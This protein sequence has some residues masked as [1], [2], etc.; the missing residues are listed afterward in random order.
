MEKLGL[1]TIKH[2]NPY[3]LHWLN[4]CGKVRINGQVLV[5]FSIERY[6]D[7]VICDVVLMHAGYILLGRP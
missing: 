7:D 2:P 6:R 4:E 3:K 1:N 5:N